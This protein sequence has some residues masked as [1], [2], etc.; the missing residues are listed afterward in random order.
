M[1]PDRTARKC[2]L[3]WL[4]SDIPV[5]FRS[6]PCG[7]AH[8]KTNEQGNVYLSPASQGK[9]NSSQFL[10]RN[11]VMQG[12]EQ[13]VASSTL[14]LAVIYCREGWSREILYHLFFCLRSSLPSV[15]RPGSYNSICLRKRN[16]ATRRFGTQLIQAIAAN[17]S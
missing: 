10:K 8:T 7:N 14:N 5:D 6:G 12:G 2:Y 17:A 4:S 15:S 13:G 9:S 11:S 16:S 3:S 1:A